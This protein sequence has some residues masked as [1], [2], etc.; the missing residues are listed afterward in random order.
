[1][2]KITFI[3]ILC[4]GVFFYSFLSKKETTQISNDNSSIVK[5]LVQTTDY[6][7]L[8]V[9][10]PMKLAEYTANNLQ[11]DMQSVIRNSENDIVFIENLGQ[12]RDTKGKRRPDVLFLTR[13]QSVDMYI[14]RTGLTYVFRKIEGDYKAEDKAK[15]V[16]TSYYRLDMEFDGMNKNF[17]VKKELAVEQQFNY[18]M[19][20]YPDGISPKAFKKITI[21]NIYDGIDLV[22]YEKEGKMK[23]D[24]IVK[25]GADPDKIKMKYEGAETL[26]LNKD[27]CVIITTSLGEIREEKPYAYSKKRGSE[28]ESGYQIQRNI[29]QFNISE[30][31]KNEDIVIDPYRIW[32][33]VYGGGGPDSGNDICTD[34]SG[35]I[36]VTGYTW[37]NFPTQTLGGAYN[38]TTNGGVTDAFVLKFNSSC[39]RLWATYY[40]GNSYDEGNSICTDNSGNVFVT[41]F[42]SGGTFPLHS[43][44]GAYNQTTWGGDDDVFILKFNNNGARQWAT[45]YGG[46]YDDNGYS[47]CADNSGT[48]YVTGYTQSINFPTQTLTGAYNQTYGGDGDVFILKF[49]SNCARIW[50][51]CYGGSYTDHGASIC[52]D[53]LDNLYI[54]GYTTSSNFP[55]Q[56]LAGAYNQTTLGGNRDVFILK[57]NSS[58]TR[59]WATYYGGWGG[60]IGHCICIDNSNN[61]YIT[62]SAG[63]DFPI[64]ILQGAY[65]QTIYSGLE[66]DAFILKFNSYSVRQ[67]ATYYGGTVLDKGYSINTDNSGNLY[68]TGET[69]STNF[70]IKTLAGAYNQSNFGGM[71]DAFIL[72]FN[73]S[74][75]RIWATYYGGMN[76]DYGFSI[77]TDNSINL[78]VTGYTN[79]N[80]PLLYLNGAYNQ[81]YPH[82]G[83][84]ILKFST[85]VGIKSISNEI[86][87]KYSLYQNYPNP[88]NPI[89]NIKFNLPKSSQT[90]L[91]VYDILGKEI[92]TLVNEKLSAG[93][94]EV[95]WDVSGYPSGV[96]FYKLITD[97]FVDVKKMLLIK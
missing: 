44:S 69:Q 73:N 19:P 16:K 40:G 89:T 14:T 30:Y 96:Y 51:T 90:K 33:T 47:I 26:Y 92:A 70:P 49:N 8:Q 35:N 84:F 22:Y 87:D 24:F 21:E 25:A 41:G 56:T 43:L 50:A 54:T 4:F 13:S 64:Q 52:M 20:E 53:S 45:Y 94:Y 86:P 36:F 55:T 80:F 67:W 34:Y 81:S 27:G 79:G 31:D 7:K 58:S 1:M 65:N 82:W 42:T 29:V 15:E 66:S 59:L 28:I 11:T 72:M 6:L 57:F 23:Y 85:M 76:P 88:F 71:W 17:K 12:I 3:L 74:G 95:D 18:Y 10:S 68:V 77:C 62:G 2:K 32:A 46:S 60:D 5:S 37:G 97:E 9:N 93:S 83:A 63:P 48:L 75:T 39:A 38:Q 78:Y 91:I 61:I